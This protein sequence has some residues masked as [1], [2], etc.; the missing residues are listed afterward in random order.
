LEKPDWTDVFL[1]LAFT[2]SKRSHD[3]QT[4][5]G[6]VLTKNNRIL[7]LG[8]NGFPARMDDDYL[9]DFRP[10][11]YPFMRHSERNAISNAGEVKGATAY[12][13]GEPCNDCLMELYHHGIEKIVYADRV[14]AQDK[15]MYDKKVRKTFLG[16]CLDSFELFPVRPDFR[17]L[18]TYMEQLSKEGVIE[19]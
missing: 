11:K 17:W 6:C 2:V 1:A 10:E 7:S 16:N 14:G 4:Q 13:T 8:F 12:V 3:S 9:P 5:H 15:A 19:W 18:R